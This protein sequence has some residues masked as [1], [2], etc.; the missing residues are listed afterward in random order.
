MATGL[1]LAV[2]QLDDECLKSLGEYIQDNDYLEIVNLCNNQITDKG[3]Q[4]LTGYLI[5]NVVLKELK[6]DFIK[7]ITNDSVMNLTEIAK[8]TNVK[9]IGIFKTSIAEEKIKEIKEMLRIPTHQ[10]EIPVKSNSKSAAKI[11]I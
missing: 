1:H 9:V 6:L 2:N 10:R 3:I 5:G 11:S 8:A 7:Q 4:I